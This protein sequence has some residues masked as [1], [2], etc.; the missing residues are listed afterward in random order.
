MAARGPKNVRRGLER[1]PFPDFWALLST[2]ATQ[3]FWSEYSFYVKV[4]TE[5]KKKQGGKR[6]KITHK[7]FD[8][9]E[10]NKMTPVL[11][12]MAWVISKTKNNSHKRTKQTCKNEQATQSTC[13]CLSTCMLIWCC[14]VI[15]SCRLAWSYNIDYHANL[16]W[17]GNLDYKM[18][19]WI[20]SKNRPSPR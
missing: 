15:W 19:F 4:D 14:R 16:G 3:V 2:F 13:T 6:K 8:V 1:C 11:H 12:Y 9:F 5:E 10:D 18:V 17:H 20:C 7:T